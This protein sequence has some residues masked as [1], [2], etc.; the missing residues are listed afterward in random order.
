[1]ITR[2]LASVIPANLQLDAA[3]AAIRA[4][5]EKARMAGADISPSLMLAWCA[6]RAMGRHAAFRRLALNDG[7]LV[8]Q[9]KFDLG[10]AVA[11]EGDRLATAV[12]A[13]ASGLAWPAFVDAYTQAVA[14]T[15]GGRVA[16]V[17]APLNLTSLGAWGI[18]C[19]T[20]IVVPPAM[21]TLFV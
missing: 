13:G 6:V 20:P 2:R 3:W 17:Q 9:E 7:T 11:L 18:E 19:A 14:E 10:V 15:R 1:A 21:S 16:E 12:I 4:A 5:R 8:D